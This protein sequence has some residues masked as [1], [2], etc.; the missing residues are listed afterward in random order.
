MSNTY[1]SVVLKLYV[2]NKS[3]APTATLLGIWN[4]LCFMVL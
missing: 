1:Y 3:V 4:Q 2:E